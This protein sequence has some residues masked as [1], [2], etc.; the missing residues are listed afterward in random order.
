MT[1]PSSLVVMVPSPSLS[2]NE[3]ASLNSEI[4]SSVCSVHGW[5]LSDRESAE[6]GEYWN[7][8]KLVCHLL[9]SDLSGDFR[10]VGVG[11]RV[12]D[13]ECVAL[14][15]QDWVGSAPQAVGLPRVLS[16]VSAQ[17]CTLGLAQASDHQRQQTRKPQNEGLPAHH[18]SK[19]DIGL[20]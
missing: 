9:I 4:C 1:V 8:Y 16:R 12:V 10:A 5:W 20:V 17:F 13:C 11:W 14:L 3:K 15:V 2:N 19:S 18:H 7:T 6:E